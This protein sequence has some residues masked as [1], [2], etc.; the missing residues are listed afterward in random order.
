[1]KRLLTYIT[2][3]TFIFSCSSADNTKA[4]QL[5]NELSIEVEKFKEEAKKAEEETNKSEITESSEV[6]RNEKEIIGKWKMISMTNLS[7]GKT[8][9]PEELY[10]T[11]KEDHK[12]ISGS[13]NRNREDTWTLHGN[14]FCQID[15]DDFEMCGSI[16]LDGN[17]LEWKKTFYNYVYEKMDQND[18]ENSPENI[19][20]TKSDYYRVEDPDGWS[21]LR[22][23]AGGEIIKRVYESEEFQVIG[24]VNNYKKI[25]LDD[26]TVGFI[27]KSRVVPIDNRFTNDKSISNKN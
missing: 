1:M 16:K 12:I 5:S 21:N 15:E 11:I 22:K 23:T 18:S 17:Q 13:S 6:N 10:I 9:F 2:I 4:N 19:A 20:N 25:K 7:N 26:G 3:L 24:K 27:H 8:S 14:N